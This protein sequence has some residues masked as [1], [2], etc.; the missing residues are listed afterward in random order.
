MATAMM[1]PERAQLNE[2][3]RRDL[4]THVQRAF[5]E[6][7]PG[8]RFHHGRH[9]EYVCAEVAALCTGDTRR[10][11]LNMPP[12]NLKS[13]IVS[14]AFATWILGKDPTKRI[15]IVS[16]GQDLAQNFARDCLRVMTAGW[17]RETYRKTRIDRDSGRMDDFRT[18]QNGGIK[19]ESILGGVTGFGADYIII[20]DPMKPNDARTDVSRT[21]VNETLQN[22][23]LSRQDGVGSARVILVM[24]RIHEDDPTGY[25]MARQPWRQVRLRA[26][27][28]EDERHAY[29]DG[30]GRRRVFRR[31]AGEA[32]NPSYES[33]EKLEEQRQIVGEYVWASQ[34]Q[35]RPAPRE[36]G[37]FKPDWFRRL[38][39]AQFPT[40]YDHVV[41]SW[42][43]GSKEG[44]TNDFSVC[45]TFGVWNGMR[46][47]LDVFRAKLE[48]TELVDAVMIQRE[49]YRPNAI[50]IEEK[51]AG[52]ELRSVLRD[53]RVWEA[54]WTL[55]TVSK[56]VRA[57]GQTRVIAGGGVVIPSDA[58]W[59]DEFLHELAVFPM[60]RH[61][62]Q[63]DALSQGL[64]YIRELI[65]DPN[66]IAFAKEELAKARGGPSRGLV[67][68]LAPPGTSHI[69]HADGRVE[70]IQD[71]HCDVLPE[72]VYGLER[73]G[74][75]RLS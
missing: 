22:T 3:T 1:S 21:K 33:L 23:V 39:L 2:A 72:A 34:Y 60:G 15:L 10:L 37:I 74:W 5:A 32:L 57:E 55:P 58:E 31:R 71:G 24:Q 53:L 38:P 40:T 35:M 20:D 70:L 69:Y 19:V 18:T 30:F 14:V 64:Q 25:L 7:N 26:V 56:V 48:F 11:V 43:T 29:V 49:K 47:I 65:H 67:R 51:G 50:V 6:L 4:Y 73:S 36:G 17:Y 75:K 44:V 8:R 28:E 66:P 54:V 68:M 63:V 45:V 62:D 9:L 59:I 12:R 46:Y 61:D 27:A 52:Q 41:Q 13:I 16:Y 42:D